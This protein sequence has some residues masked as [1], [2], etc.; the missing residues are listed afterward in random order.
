MGDCHCIKVEWQSSVAD[1]TFCVRQGLV[2]LPERLL[3]DAW[4]ASCIKVG[5]SAT[6]GGVSLAPILVEE[7]RLS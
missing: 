2:T 3:G 7:R 5:F 4:A 1:V 6:P